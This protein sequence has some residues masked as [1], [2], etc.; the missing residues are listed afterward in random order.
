MSAITA[1]PVGVAAVASAAARPLQRARLAT[2]PRLARRGPSWAARPLVATRAQVEQ[3]KTSPASKKDN[4]DS[5][6]ETMM[7]Q[8]DGDGQVIPIEA[9][10]PDV[11]SMPETKEAEPSPAGKGKRQR[12]RGFGAPA[13]SAEGLGKTKKVGGFG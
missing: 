5:A 7:S 11:G 12:Q 13:A 10:V 9:A 4:V 8:M 3:G 6:V 1:Q 2:A